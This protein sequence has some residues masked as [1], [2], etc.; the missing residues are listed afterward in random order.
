MAKRTIYLWC[1]RTEVEG[2]LYVDG[3]SSTYSPNT[4]PYEIEEDHPFFKSPGKYKLDNDVLVYDNSRWEKEE[5]EDKKRQ[6]EEKRRQEILKNIES[7]LKGKDGEVAELKGTVDM[8]LKM[9]EDQAVMIYSLLSELG[10]NPL[11]DPPADDGDGEV[12]VEEEA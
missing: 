8:L 2:V 7:I 4:I 6:E 3:W 10:R 11:D 9:N 5:E 1:I 12:P